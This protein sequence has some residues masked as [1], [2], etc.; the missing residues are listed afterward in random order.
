MKIMKKFWEKNKGR[1]AGVAFILLIL[2]LISFVSALILLAFGV[3]YFEDGVKLNIELFREFR[4][5]W[6]GWC[7]LILVQVVVTTLLCFVPGLSMAFI[8]MMQAL[9]SNPWQAFAVAFIGVMLSSLIMY[10]AGRTG[11]YKLCEKVLGDK[12]CKKASELL[13]HRGTVFFPLMMLFPMFP[14]DALVMVAGTLRMSLKWFI[15]SIIVGRGIGVATIIFGTASVISNEFT[16]PWQWALYIG[17]WAIFIVA[18][19]YAAYRFNK[20]LDKRR[21]AAEEKQKEESEK[22]K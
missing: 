22:G 3:I 16:S 14:D 18:V 17:G 2:A 4:D 20:Y 21:I 1:I 7:I 12:D 8:L 10:L 15:P 9:F 19:F 11:G 13:N 6:Y 5:S